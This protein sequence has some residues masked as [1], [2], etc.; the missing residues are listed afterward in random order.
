LPLASVVSMATLPLPWMMPVLV[1]L[2]WLP[3]RLRLP[4]VPEA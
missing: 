1:L 4:L 3:E 2:S